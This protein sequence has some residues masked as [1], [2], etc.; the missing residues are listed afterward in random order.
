MSVYNLKNNPIWYQFEN[1]TA[2]TI[3]KLSGR[4]LIDFCEEIKSKES[5][6]IAASTFTLKVKHPTEVEYTTTLDDDYFE[7][8]CNSDFKTLINMF[9]IKRINPVKVICP[10]MSFPFS[11][12]LIFLCHYRIETQIHSFIHLLSF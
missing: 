2:S 1:R 6:E 9:N 4:E 7:N 11:L 5:L 12:L 10:G 8:N 3:R